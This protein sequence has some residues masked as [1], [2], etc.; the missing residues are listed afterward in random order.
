MKSLL[1]AD[2]LYWF[3]QGT[4]Y[5]LYE[6]LGAHVVDGGTWFAVWAPNATAVSVI[7]DWN[8]WKPGRDPLAP[9]GSSGIWEGGVAK[10]GHGARYKFAITG[11]DGVVRDK[12]DPCAARA[13]HPPATASVVW[14]ARHEWSDA[15]WLAERKAR[16]ARDAP[17]SIYEMHA[18]S[19]RRAHNQVLGYRELGARLGDHARAL[20]FT[21]VELMPLM[22]HP[23]YGS[24]GYQ[25]TGYFA[26]TSRY[27]S[28][29]DLRYLIDELHKA[30][31]GVI[32]D[33]VPAHFPRDAHG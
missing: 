5:R 17:V 27:G 31:I 15:A 9:R 3:N 10:I 29:D 22:E 21:H 1:T 28:P 16:I 25:V 6:K 18:G 23:F 8:G 33:W 12:A 20:G 2:D 11:P 26:P 30:N 7:G 32:L 24:W 19:W 14:H 13:E 4:H